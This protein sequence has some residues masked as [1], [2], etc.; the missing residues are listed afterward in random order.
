MISRYQKKSGQSCRRVD[1]QPTMASPSHSLKP[2]SCVVCH[3]RKVKCNRK[4]P[5]SNCAKANIECIY[6]PPPPPRRRKR[7]RDSRGNASQEREKS[8]RQ[9][10]PEPL[11][12]DRPVQKLSPTTDEQVQARSKPSGSGR[13]IM[14]EGHSVYL[15]KLVIS[16]TTSWV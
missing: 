4:E 3:N 5:C 9:M 1:A 2:Y 8:L 12:V 14:K 13:M 7:E 15:D 16:W 11:R 6:H 10:T